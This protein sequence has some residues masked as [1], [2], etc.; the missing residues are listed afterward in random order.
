MRHSIPESGMWFEDPH[1]TSGVHMSLELLWVWPWK[2]PTWLSWGSA[3]ALYQVGSTRCSRSSVIECRTRCGAIESQVEQK[4][5]KFVS[6][7][8]KKA[9]P[10]HFFHVKP[11]DVNRVN[12]YAYEPIKG[13]RN[14]HS[15]RYVCG[16]NGCEQ[17]NEEKHVILLLFLCWWQFCYL[18][19][20]ALDWRTGGWGPHSLQHKICTW[21]TV[22]CILWS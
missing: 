16:C 7:C 22:G 9:C 12:Q 6:R 10:S 4:T 1:I 3:Q 19:E 18:W 5:W 14:L 2:R 20:F 13:I 21:C 15:I 11:D 8:C 17:D